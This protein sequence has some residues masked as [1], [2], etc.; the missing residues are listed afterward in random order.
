M[1][2]ASTVVPLTPTASSSK[3]R[4]HNTSAY[5]SISRGIQG[6]TQIGYEWIAGGLPVTF[7]LVITIGGEQVYNQTHTVNTPASDT[8]TIR[9]SSTTPLTAGQTYDVVFTIL[10]AVDSNGHTVEIVGGNPRTEQVTIGNW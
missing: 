3:L 8:G 6:N 4:W 5:N 9:F 10:G 2:A 7:V 1:A